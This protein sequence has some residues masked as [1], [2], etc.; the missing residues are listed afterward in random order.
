MPQRDD[1]LGVTYQPRPPGADVHRIAWERQQRRALERSRVRFIRAAAK[2][3]LARLRDPLAR[4]RVRVRAPRTVARRQGGHRTCAATRAG[5]GDPD[6]D[7]D[8]FN[9]AAAQGLL[10]GVVRALGL[11][12]IGFAC[13]VSRCHFNEWRYGVES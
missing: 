2:A 6:P 8:P 4:V 3:H 13:E 10:S 5:P 7:G 12:R 1:D 9:V 11:W